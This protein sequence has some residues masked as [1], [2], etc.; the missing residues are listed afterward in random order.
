MSD[1]EC[2]NCGEMFDKRGI[3]AHKAHCSGGNQD[4]DPDEPEFDGLEAEVYERDDGACLRCD[5][6][7]NLTIHTVNPGVRAEKSNLVTICESC[8]AE[9]GDLHHR[10]KRTKIRSD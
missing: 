3:G 5:A 10:T 7:E 6:T 4:E 9:I 8:E 1:V 2:E